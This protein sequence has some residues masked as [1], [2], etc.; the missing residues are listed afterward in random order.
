[1][2][3]RDAPLHELAT[4]AVKVCMLVAGEK[5]KE[6]REQFFSL[7]FFQ[8][9]SKSG[10]GFVLLVEGGRIDHAHHDTWVCSRRFGKAKNI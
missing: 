2:E 4:T 8:M 7:V 9:L 5:N 10:N 6:S 1:M 3:G